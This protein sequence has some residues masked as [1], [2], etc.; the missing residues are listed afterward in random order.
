MERLPGL[1][2]VYSLAD[3]LHIDV[4]Q[5]LAMPSKRLTYWIAYFRVKAA[6][7]E[8]QHKESEIKARM[9]RRR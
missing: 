4:D 7:Q 9:G 6:E 8:R 5:V 1:M 3:A 2:T